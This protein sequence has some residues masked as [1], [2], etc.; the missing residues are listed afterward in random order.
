MTVDAKKISDLLSTLEGE[1]KTVGDAQTNDADI[2]AKYNDLN[3]EERKTFLESLENKIKKDKPTS[4]AYNADVYIL[5]TIANDESPNGADFTHKLSK[6]DGRN[7]INTSFLI[8][9]QTQHDK[10]FELA[11]V[12]RD[13]DKPVQQLKPQQQPIDLNADIKDVNDANK[14]VL[15]GIKDKTGLDVTIGNKH[16]TKGAELNTDLN[17]DINVDDYTKTLAAGYIAEAKKTNATPDAAGFKKYIKDHVN[18]LVDNDP[19][20]KAFGNDASMKDAIE[21]YKASR[22]KLLNDISDSDDQLGKGLTAGQTVTNQ[23][24]AQNKSIWDILHD[25][26]GFLGMLGDLLKNIFDKKDHNN[27]NLQ[28]GNNVQQPQGSNVHQQQGNGTLGS[29]VHDDQSQ[30]NS[31]H[32]GASHDGIIV[33]VYGLVFGGIGS[34]LKQAFAH[35]PDLKPSDKVLIGNLDD[36]LGSAHMDGSAQHDVKLISSLEDLSKLV[37]SK[38]RIY[39][40]D[41]NLSP[42][43]KEQLQKVTANMAS[44][45]VDDNGNHVAVLN[46]DG[47]AV[48]ADQALMDKILSGKEYTTPQTD[49]NPL[50]VKGADSKD[51]ISGRSDTEDKFRKAFIEYGQSGDDRHDQRFQMAEDDIKGRSDDKK[52]NIKKFMNILDKDGDLFTPDV[53]DYLEGKITKEDLKKKNSDAYKTA[54]LLDNAVAEAYKIVNDSGP[55]VTNESIYANVRAKEKE[56]F[57]R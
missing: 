21:K 20:I 32:N 42:K 38:E 29:M 41:G 53:Q 10:L 17:K 5:Q 22:V 55:N 35:K 28:Q 51:R 34:R 23:A 19:M 18:D 25:Q 3:A 31:N 36:M 27:N 39:D 33:G 26:G 15:A 9:D 30:Y 49:Y 47:K 46:S 37:E 8:T 13:S 12:A 1:A 40:K 54:E 56:L 7:G 44:H 16:Y 45:L 48:G 57:Q 2:R 43:F 50:A 52:G 24:A 6:A 14:A 4:A 11:A